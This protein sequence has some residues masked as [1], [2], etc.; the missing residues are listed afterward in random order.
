[1]VPFDFS[2]TFD[3]MRRFGQQPGLA[4]VVAK[5]DE[6]RSEPIPRSLQILCEQLQRLFSQL[7]ELQQAESI[8]QLI[9][10]HEKWSHGLGA[11]VT[12]AEHGVDGAD[13]PDLHAAQF[14]LVIRTEA[15][16]QH[17]YVCISVLGVLIQL[18]SPH[19]WR[20]GLSTGSVSGLIVSMKSRLHGPEATVALDRLER[21][22]QF[23]SKFIVHFQV[24]AMSSWITYLGA[25]EQVFLIYFVPAKEAA[26]KIQ[27]S[28]QPDPYASDFRPPV[29]H[30]SFY[31]APRAAEAFEALDLIIESTFAEIGLVAHEETEGKDASSMG[32]T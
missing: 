27:S 31:T 12:V 23:R 32:S 8:I 16:F 19:A 21:A 4:S 10:K 25:D 29:E 1:M 26:P 14:N 20:R 11:A 17:V 24:H 5:L 15:F 6:R 22:V 18:L 30:S 3:L 2:L 7:I 13:L 28:F 9:S